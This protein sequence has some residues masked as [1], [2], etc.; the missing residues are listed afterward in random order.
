MIDYVITLQPNGKMG[1]RIKKEIYDSLR[2]AMLGLLD[3]QPEISSQ[4]FFGILNDQFVGELGDNTGWYLYQV[5][6]DMQTRG[7]ITTIHLRKRGTTKA[8]IKRLVNQ[9][10]ARKVSATKNIE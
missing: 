2:T 9:L 3:K 8:I 4:S 7:I 1:I 6:L 10:S 5:K